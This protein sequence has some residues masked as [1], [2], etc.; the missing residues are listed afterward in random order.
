[1]NNIHP[2][3]MDQDSNFYNESAKLIC[4]Y[5]DI[6]VK[7]MALIDQSV[8]ELGDLG[9]GNCQLGSKTGWADINY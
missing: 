5:H 6:T 2:T 3:I 1:M 8:S 9:V 7:L 4:I